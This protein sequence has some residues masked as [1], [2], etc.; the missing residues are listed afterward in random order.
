MP[1]NM[2]NASSSSTAGA[3]ADS[4]FPEPPTN[5]KLGGMDPVHHLGC[6]FFDAGGAPSFD[7]RGGTGA[8]GLY[9]RTTKKDGV[10]APAAADK[11]ILSTGAVDWLRLVD[12]GTGVGVGISSVYRVSTA[13]GDAEACTVTGVGSQSV[14]YTAMYWFYD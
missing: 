2:Q 5:L 11:G 8:E 3:V 7:L 9:D 4:P 13:G 6:H 10:A 1:L 14:A 12:D